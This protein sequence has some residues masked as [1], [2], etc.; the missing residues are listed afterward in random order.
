M[1]STSPLVV[2][3][4]EMSA[5]PLAVSVKKAFLRAQTQG[6]QTPAPTS[7]HELRFY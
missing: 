6:L 1:R 2:S 4:N 7:A 5:K 3:V